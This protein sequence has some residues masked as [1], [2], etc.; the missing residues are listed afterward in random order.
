VSSTDQ[1][2]FKHTHHAPRITHHESRIT[3]HESRIRN[4]DENGDLLRTIVTHLKCPRSWITD[5]AS[6]ITTTLR[7]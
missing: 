5:L 6:R 3:H 2:S 4:Y 7:R 1:V